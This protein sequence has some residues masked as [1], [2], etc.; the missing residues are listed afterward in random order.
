MTLSTESLLQAFRD[1]AHNYKR[2]QLG[3][4]QEDIQVYGAALINKHGVSPELLD[5]IL[6]EIADA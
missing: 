4:Y 6:Q 3:F 2:S 1:S 5:S